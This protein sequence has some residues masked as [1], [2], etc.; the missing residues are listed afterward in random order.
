M[1]KSVE[2]FVVDGKVM[3]LFKEDGV[4]VRLEDNSDRWD[5][6][7]DQL[8][9]LPHELEGFFDIPYPYD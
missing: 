2:V 8:Q 7:Y 6:T 5:N 9:R 3:T 1:A 4:P